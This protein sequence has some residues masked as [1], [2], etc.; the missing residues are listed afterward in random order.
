MKDG[1]GPYMP[2]PGWNVVRIRYLDFI[3]SLIIFIFR[4]PMGFFPSF[5][6]AMKDKG[7]LHFFIAI[8]FSKFLKKQSIDA[9][10][11]FEGKHALWI[12]YYCH[13]F[14][15]IPMTVLVHAEMVETKSKINLTKKAINK[16][17]KII[18]ISE[19]N[20]KGI[21]KQF[22][23]PSEK[24]DV[25]RLFA[26]FQEDMTIKILIVGEWSE[27]KGHETLLRAIQE[28][29]TEDFKVWVVGGGAWGS[30][31]FNVEKYVSE[32]NLQKKVVIWGKVSEDL[33]KL[34]YNNCDIFCLPS[35]TTKKGVKEGIP[36][37]LME[38]MFFAK[39]VISTYH[40][41]IPELVPE[42]L[43]HENDHEALA[44]A[45]IKLRSPE[46]R[47]ELGA[48]NKKIIEEN[49]SKRNV[50]KIAQILQENINETG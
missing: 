44:R 49:Y 29:G 9:I 41:G 36:V 47:R 40:T 32:Q 43:I 50:R 15:N 7:L 48:R 34:L 31:Y 19:Y 42:I 25:V 1:K 3:L 20:K 6:S 46:L 10:Y 28:P 22:Q 21:I 17:Y 45:L 33:L 11:C 8:Y 26:D 38:A 30:D 27:R 13:L 12:G 4:R 37:A 5:I 35:K 16:C 14:T 39:P 18:T 2:T 24:I 23:V